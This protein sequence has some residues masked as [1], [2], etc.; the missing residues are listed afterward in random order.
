MKSHRDQMIDELVEEVENWDVATL[1]D[2]AQTIL[3]DYY[4]NL[5][6]DGVEQHYI[7]TFGVED[8]PETFPDGYNEQ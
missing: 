7:K 4:L 2:F 3:S 6:T 8:Y 1:V 5:S